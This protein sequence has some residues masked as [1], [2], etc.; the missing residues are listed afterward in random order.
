MNGALQWHATG[1]SGN[2]LY[3]TM[4]LREEPIVQFLTPD[5][6]V[7]K[8]FAGS[9]LARAIQLWLEVQDETPET[10]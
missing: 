9:I 1:P 8:S 2:T 7:H 6:K 10:V 4:R 5:D 3:P